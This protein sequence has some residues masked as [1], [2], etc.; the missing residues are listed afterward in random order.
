MEQVQE[1]NGKL[2]KSVVKL[3]NFVLDS[4]SNTQSN[5]GRASIEPEAKTDSDLARP[6]SCHHPTMQQASPGVLTHSERSAPR[7]LSHEAGGPKSQRLRVR[8]AAAQ[9]CCFPDD[10]GIEEEQACGGPGP[11][12]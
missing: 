8:R 6:P 4:N 10:S 5:T 3:E 2:E 7:A 9:G 11:T 1:N 12:L